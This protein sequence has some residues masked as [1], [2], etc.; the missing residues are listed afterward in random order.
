MI[1]ERREVVRYYA[2]HTVGALPTEDGCGT[3]MIVQRKSFSR[4]LDAYRW[5]ARGAIFRRRDKQG[6]PLSPKIRDPEDGSCY[7][8]YCS[9]SRWR[10]IVERMA[11]LLAYYDGKVDNA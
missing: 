11:R 2:K 5:V 9:E 7:C 4:Q 3:T 8:K 1:V 10:P 6:C